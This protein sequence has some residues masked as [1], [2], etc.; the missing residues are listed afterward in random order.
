MGVETKIL[1]QTE[2]VAA[3]LVHIK[4]VTYKEKNKKN[5]LL[6]ILK[7]LLLAFPIND[8]CPKISY[9]LT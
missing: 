6:T 9:Q 2:P 1:R 8:D 3:G 4:P 7:P 5:P